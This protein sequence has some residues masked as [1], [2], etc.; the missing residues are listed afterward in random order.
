MVLVLCLSQVVFAQKKSEYKG[1]PMRDAQAK[2]LT[3]PL[4]VTVTVENRTGAALNRIYVV[5]ECACYY[6]G[7]D[8]SYPDRTIGVING[9][10]DGMGMIMNSKTIVLPSITYFWELC[11]SI[12]G[13]SRTY[14]AKIQLDQVGPINVDVNLNKNSVT[15]VLRDAANRSHVLEFE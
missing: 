5:V 13:I 4:F 3:I 6:Y 9:T 1:I 15:G 10:V 2:S 11:I 7:G 8:Y 14:R 12:T